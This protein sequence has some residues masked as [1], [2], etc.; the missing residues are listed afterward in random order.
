MSPF[1]WYNGYHNMAYK[2]EKQIGHKPGLLRYDDPGNMC[3]GATGKI[4][5]SSFDH[6]IEERILLWA[7][8]IYAI[9]QYY[10]KDSR[11]RQEKE[12]MLQEYRLQG[13]WYDDPHDSAAVKWGY[14]IPMNSYITDE[15]IS[16]WKT[17]LFYTQNIRRK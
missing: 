2:L 10:L 14:Q 7:A 5:I 6:V 16:S 9:Q 4:L 15:Q 8:E 1:F 3:Y 17:F 13:G 11:P 12:K